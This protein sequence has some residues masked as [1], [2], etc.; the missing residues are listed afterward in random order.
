MQVVAIV[1]RKHLQVLIDSGS[2]HNFLT[3]DIVLKLGLPLVD[4][5]M[6]NMKIA[7]GEQ[8]HCSK[9]YKDFQWK[10][11]GYLI[12]TDVFIIHLENYDL[13]LDAQWLA[14]LGDI[15]WNFATLSMRFQYNNQLCTLLG[16]QS[17]TLHRIEGKCLDKLILKCNTPRPQNGHVSLLSIQYTIQW[18]RLA[19]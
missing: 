16:R 14:S 8:L 10:V 13:I 2:T 5:P 1:G 18:S 4:I 15:N 6:V 11:Q 19:I 7:N 17:A 3:D 12:E 9:M